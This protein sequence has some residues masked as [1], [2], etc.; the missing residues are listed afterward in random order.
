MLEEFLHKQGI[1]IALLQEVTNPNLQSIR[2]YTAHI[3]QGAEGRGTAIL[4]KEGLS[5]SNIKRLLSGRGMAAIFNGTWILSIYAPSGAE[6]KTER[7]RFYTN[8]LTQL[9][10]TTHTEL[11]LAG[12]FNC[13]LDTAD[14]TGHKNFSRALASIVSGFRLHDVWDASRSRQGYTHYAP[15]TASLFGKDI[16]QTATA[17]T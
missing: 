3:N 7:E 10:P 15:R 9:L 17:V 2:R 1:D 13:I 11:I 12:D 6:K 14:S 16:R 8:D 4:T 5:I